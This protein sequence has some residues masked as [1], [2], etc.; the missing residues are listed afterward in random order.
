MDMLTTANYV[1]QRLPGVTRRFRPV[2]VSADGAAVQGTSGLFLSPRSGLP[3]PD[4]VDI[5]IVASGPPAILSPRQMRDAIGGQQC[6]VSWLRDVHAAGGQLASC[7]T[8]SFLIAAT[9]LLDG[10][11]A[12][13]HWRAEPAFQ[14]L[15]PLVEL[16]IDSLR[17]EEERIVTGGGAHTF[18]TT[19]L[20]LIRHCLGEEVATGTAKLLLAEGHASGQNAFRQWV[21]PHEHGD[22]VIARGQQWLEDHFTQPFDLESFAGQLHL[23]P[24]TLMRRFK[25]ATG[26]A[27]LQYQQRLRVEA[28]KAALESTHTAVNQ[29]VWQVGYEDVSSFQRLFK[30]E[31]GLTMV[32]YRQRFGGKRHETLGAFDAA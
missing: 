21:M 6:V 30:R 26:M 27:P 14:A 8:G 32:E 23:A 16:R 11:L 13:T 20:G 5:A 10:K 12:T 7:C 3:H 4:S 28:A 18:S 15:Y 9:G 19:I 24:R 25:Q 1:A 2:L 22:A 29:V 17:V 31:T